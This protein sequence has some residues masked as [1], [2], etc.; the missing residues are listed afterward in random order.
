V[1]LARQLVALV[2]VVGRV[3]QWVVV[4]L[5]GKELLAVFMAAVVVV[6]RIPLRQLA[7]PALQMAQFAL[8]GPVILAHSHQLA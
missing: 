4:Q 5:R 7:R 1:E 6:M 3:G 8:S 2:A